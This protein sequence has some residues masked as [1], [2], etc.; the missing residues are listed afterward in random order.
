MG[1]YPALLSSDTVSDILLAQPSKTV[2]A[3]PS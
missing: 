2:N 3:T 1:H